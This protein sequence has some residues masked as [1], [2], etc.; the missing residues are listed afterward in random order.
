M[1]VDDSRAAA[2]VV[3]LRYIAR[4]TSSADHI[5]RCFA[6]LLGAGHWRALLSL[7]T[8][9]M[10]HNSD[11]RLQLLAFAIKRVAS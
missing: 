1:S 10:S 7:S 5:H 8:L 11:G 6:R 4:P 9:W 3:A 2:G